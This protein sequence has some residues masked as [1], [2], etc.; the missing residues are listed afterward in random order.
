MRLR[1]ARA[2]AVA[3]GVLAFALPAPAQVHTG[4]IDIVVTDTTGAVLPGATV[5]A[6]GPSNHSAVTDASGAARFLNLPPGT[7]QIIV[8]LPGFN[9]YVNRNVP[10][11]VGAGV[12]LRVGLSLA[13]VAQDVE[14]TAES[15]VLDPRRTAT[16]TNVTLDELQNVPSSRDPWVVLQT[17]PTIVVDRVNVGGSESGQQSNYFAKG[18]AFGDNTWSID[19]V[20][21]TDMAALGA[22]PT[23]YDFDMFQEMQVTTGGSDIQSGTAGVQL[24]MVLKSGTNRFRGS[25]RV[26]FSSEDMQANNLPTDL[27]HLGGAGGKGNRTDQYSD[28]GV[29]AGGP[30][31]RDRLW[32]W[33]SY[34]KT[35]VRIVTLIDTGDRTILENSGFKLQGQA[36]DAVRGNFTFFRGDKIKFGRDAS[37]TRPPA[38]TWNQDG[39]TSL[40]KGE[41]NFVA[42]QNLFLTARGAYVDGGFQLIPVGGMGPDVV[43]G[44]DNVWQGS[45][46]QA[47]FSRPQHTVMG[48]GNYFLGRHEIK[49]GGHWRRSVSQS[50]VQWPGALGGY[51]RH[52]ASGLTTVFIIRPYHV[53]FES[54]YTGA[55][56]SD[57]I[58]WD[59]LTLNLGVRLDHAAASANEATQAANP[60][61]PDLFPSITAPAVDNV[62]S[63]TMAAP[64]AG[65]SYALDDQRRTLVRASYGM[66]GSQLASTAGSV[67][68][69]ASY[70]WQY[71]LVSGVA[72]GQPATDAH[73]RAGTRLAFAGHDPA[74]PTAT[75]TFNRVDP[76]LKN[77]KTHEVILGI[78]RE[79]ARNLGVSASYSYRR[80]V[81]LAWQP[82]I[83]I[84]STDY[85]QTGALTGT[86]PGG[87]SFGVPFYGLIPGTPVPTGR[88]TELTTREGYHQTFNGFEAQVT[89]R[90]ADRWFGRFGFSTNSHR[91]FFTN[92]ATSLQDPTP[93]QANPNKHGGQVVRSTGGSGKSQIF[94]LA[95]RYQFVANGM[96]QGPWGVNFGLNWVYREGFGKLYYQTGVVTGDPLGSIKSILVV[97]DVTDH[98]LPA[99]SNLDLRI[100]KAFNVA[101][102]NINVDLDVFNVTNAATVL[103][104]EYAVNLTTADRVREIMQPR[105]LRLGFRLGW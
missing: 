33:G 90:M 29:E 32:A 30:L 67:L 34:G 74:N 97:D 4:R 16:A 44:A 81:D 52:L 95:P 76:N 8:R 91:E 15:P 84:R 9:D 87:G 13:G 75:Q 79:L 102:T 77:P 82:L 47:I 65:V 6:T 36:S 101:R 21:I 1:I 66:F 85:Q 103:G 78:D 48:D 63:H 56:V 55:Y 64:R 58:S 45:Y 23:Y 89:K 73:L 2:L 7:Y 40:Y 27:A 59:R 60:G 20:P 22:S 41:V 57:T 104:R 35:D 10:V 37:P 53:D 11:A 99:L 69:G 46:V 94:I 105:I 24:N 19:G 39:P 31:V 83:G 62:R 26:Y 25:S 96:Y 14:V 72:P 38:T 42:R 54:T 43:L 86:I 51:T 80:F 98:R 18:A 88:G 17:V 50:D 70:A 12:P 71:Y 92:P 61:V 49:F 3:I 5:E 68:S 28:Y 100:G 93:T